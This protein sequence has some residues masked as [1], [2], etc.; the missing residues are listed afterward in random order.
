MPKKRSKSLQTAIDKLNH[1]LA[2]DE[3]VVT[4]VGYDIPQE[5][6]NIQLLNQTSLKTVRSYSKD[7]QLWKQGIADALETLLHA[8]DTY[9]GY[10]FLHVNDEDR[11]FDRKYF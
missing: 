1:L 10:M 11:K 5:D 4:V 6:R 7:G 8:H 2:L 3:V 9:N